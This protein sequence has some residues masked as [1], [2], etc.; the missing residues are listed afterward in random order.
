MSLHRAGLWTL[1]PSLACLLL[2]AA[3]QSDRNRGD[4]SAAPGRRMPLLPAELGNPSVSR[5]EAAA[6]AQAACAEFLAA[7]QPARQAPAAAPIDQHLARADGYALL[8]AQ[9]DPKWQQL[10]AAIS[11]F[12][13]RA[14]VFRTPVGVTIVNGRAAVD[15]LTAESSGA[16]AVV[17][18]CR[19]V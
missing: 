10:S 4:D 5:S 19:A 6:L 17:L 13:D 16:A 8:A 15:A 14:A 12:L 11:A 9:A 2:L 18:L 1:V 3:C 7:T